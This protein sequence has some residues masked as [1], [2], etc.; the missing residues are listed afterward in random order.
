MTVVE[1]RAFAFAEDVLKQAVGVVDAAIKEIAFKG[2]RDPKV[3]GLALLCRSISN[4]QGAL[5]MARHNQAVECRTLVRSC[6]ENLFLVDQLLQDG[7]GFLKTMRSHEA[8]GRIL[9][10]E[11]LLKRGAAD[12][13]EGQTI[14]G[15]IKGQRAEFP[16][17]NKLTVSETAKSDVSN[18]YSDYAMLS[19]DAA[20][21]SIT[22]LRRH[23]RPDHTGRL[24]MDIAP[25]FKPRERLTTLDM[26]CDALFG[27]CIHVS[28]LL[29][30]TSQDDA[31]GALW[32]R[33]VSQRLDAAG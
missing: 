22:A 4:F 17:P 16:R 18:L 33:F 26:A 25:P 10:G 27:A 31:L 5:T 3:Y 13:P 20:H 9:L 11:A 24:T 21:P 28:K 19:H 6:W 23:F 1:E 7:A 8:W 29:G 12:S 32:E 15:L 30:G 14:R 2:K